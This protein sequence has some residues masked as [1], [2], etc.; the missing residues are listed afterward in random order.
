MIYIK[1]ELFL[2]NSQYL[3]TK[4]RFSSN[5]K[6]SSLKILDTYILE[7]LHNII[8]EIHKNNEKKQSCILIKQ[9]KNKKKIITLYYLK[10][11]KIQ[12]N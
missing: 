9:N 2:L 8:F 5:T 3:Y 10:V 6:A 4:T 12:M 1:Q 11:P 7:K